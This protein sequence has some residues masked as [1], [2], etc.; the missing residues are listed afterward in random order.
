MLIDKSK[1]ELRKSISPKPKF[2]GFLKR[3]FFQSALVQWVLIATI[4]LALSSWSITI[5]FIRPV[6]L[7][8]VLHYNVYLGV[9][10]I[11]G[12]WQIYFLPAISSLFLV[13][14]TVLAYLF[15]QKKERLGAYIFLLASFFVEAGTLIAIAG[16]VMINY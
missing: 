2:L 10:I 15:Y 6:D 5:F 11:G 7:P 4:F 9:D 13:T 16:L 14:N 3:E 8:L 1:I 12:W